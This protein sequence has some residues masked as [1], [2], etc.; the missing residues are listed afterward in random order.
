M[1]DVLKDA[2]AKMKKAIEVLKQKY[3]AVRTGRATPALVEHLKVEYYGTQVPL[4]Q[5]AGISVPEAHTIALQ[6]YDKGAIKDIE[7]AIMKSELGVTPKTD[8]GVIRI[9]L[10][11]LNEE[12]RKELVKMIKKEAED[13]KIVIRN[14]RR[15]AMETLKVS[16]EKKEITEDVEKLKEEEAQKITDR[17]IAETDKAAAAKEKE[18]MEV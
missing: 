14:L 1:T 6:P 7:K 4:Q 17:E 9:N 18:I 11:P 13:A 2:E 12:R 5:L 16:K 8:S 3:A 15:E 10:P